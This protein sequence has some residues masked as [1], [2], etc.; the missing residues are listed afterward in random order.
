MSDPLQIESSLDSLDV[1][2][3]GTNWFRLDFLRSISASDVVSTLLDFMT[4]VLAWDIAVQIN[5]SSGIATS[6][7]TILLTSISANV[8]NISSHYLVLIVVC[9]I[10]L[11][12]SYGFH[13]SAAKSSSTQERHAAAQATFTSGLVLCS[14]MGFLHA[15]IASR[16]VGITTVVLG[17][18]MIWIRRALWRERNRRRHR[19][20]L[21]LRNILIVGSGRAGR[22]IRRHLDS[23]D[24]LGVQFKG[25]LACSEVEG[26][27]EDMDVVGGLHDLA[28]IAR[29]SFADELVFATTLDKVQMEEILAQARTANLG[30]RIIPAPYEGLAGG[31]NLDYMGKLP[32]IVL[33]RKRYAAEAMLLKRLVDVT[34][35]F[36]LLLILSPL[37]LLIAL[38]VRLDSEGSILYRAPRVGLKG[39]MFYCYKFRT[40]VS[41]ADSRRLELAAKNERDGILF[42]ISNDPRVTRVG[43]FLRKYSLDEIPQCFNVLAGDM[44]LVGPRPPLAEEVKRYEPAHLRRLDVMPG[45]TGLWQVEGRGDPSFAS[46]I[47]LDTSYIENWTFWL[48]IKIMIRTIGVVLRG[49]GS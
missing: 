14:F 15:D 48:D 29:S 41:D 1:L 12:V 2:A 49:T 22:A 37:L 18:T 39:R 23:H 26:R 36:F 10:S 42:K 7:S 30:V 6:H 28:S 19:K 35:A 4:V 9:I 24:D 34:L 27:C 44:S 25:F 20:G 43:A 32:T 8:V 3:P 11:S 47:A 40:M 13:R 38:V 46:Y 45:I 33:H 17:G 31:A 16:H 5:A 21:D